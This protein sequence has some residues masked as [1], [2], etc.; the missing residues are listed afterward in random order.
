MRLFHVL[1]DPEIVT[2]FLKTGTRTPPAVCENG[3]PADAVLTQIG[4]RSPCDV[5]GD[6]IA[7]FESASSPDGPTELVKPIFRKMD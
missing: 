4:F 6:V 5:D 1:L 3:L 2:D 7:T